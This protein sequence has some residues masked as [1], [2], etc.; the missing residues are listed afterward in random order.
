MKHLGWLLA[1]LTLL[2]GCGSAIEPHQADG[3][4][5]NFTAAE[6]ACG[7]ASFCDPGERGPKGSYMRQHK[8]GLT[9]DKTDVVGTCRPK[10]AAG[11]ACVDVDQ[12]VSGQ[13]VHP[14]ATPSPV[15]KGVCK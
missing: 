8:Y 12:C 1:A 14:G 3:S 13:C 11:A 7:A 10:G 4:D 2:T 15:A 9:G 5:C 6:T